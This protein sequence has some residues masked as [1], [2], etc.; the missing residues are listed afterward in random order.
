MTPAKVIARLR[1]LAKDWRHEE[2][3]LCKQYWDVV[4]PQSMR[5]RQIKD[6]QAIDAAVEM[7]GRLE[8]AESA[9]RDDYQNWMT[10]LDRNAEPLAKLEADEKERDW[11]AERCEDAMNECEAL[12]A[13]IEGVEDKRMI[14][15]RRIADLMADLNR[16]GHEND[17]LRAKAAEMGRQE[18]VGVLHVGSYYGEELQDWEFEADQRVCDHLNERHVSNPTSLKLYA[19][20]GAQHAPSINEGVRKVTLGFRWESE[21]Q[22]HIPTIEIEFDP[23]SPDSP[24]DAKG[25]QDRDRIASMLSPESK[26]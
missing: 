12:R 22:H 3:Q 15:D 17:A 9:R 6:T 7:I 19:L 24:N 13:K 11:H 23:V 21:A 2:E 4:V 8:A 10:A 16:V 14:D 1:R 20:P 5:A 25:W 26:P 18:S